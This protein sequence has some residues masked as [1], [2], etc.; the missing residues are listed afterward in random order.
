MKLFIIVF[1]FSGCVYKGINYSV[2]FSYCKGDSNIMNTESK[3]RCATLTL[4]KEPEE[5]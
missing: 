2:D 1:I 3:D 4:T 5:E